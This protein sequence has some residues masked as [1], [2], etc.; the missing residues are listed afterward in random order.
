MSCNSWFFNDF[1][2]GEKI[3]NK[4]KILDYIAC[5]PDE[6]RE[7]P[8]FFEKVYNLNSETIKEIESIYKEVEQR[9][10]VNSAFGELNSDK[11]KKFVSS[12]IREIDLRIEEYL[13]DFAEDKKSEENCEKAK[14]KLL[15]ISLTKK[16]LQKL[17]AVWRNYKNNHKSWK[18]L[19]GEISEFLEGKL[20]LEREE[21]SPYNPE[22]LKLIT[23]DFVS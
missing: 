1:V 12:L 14:E 13:L 18:R 6:V 5:L 20:S 2:K 19:L 9:E 15:T 7:I 17:R 8:D 21:I 16:R 3:T 11:S 23:I 4:T 22:L 10:T